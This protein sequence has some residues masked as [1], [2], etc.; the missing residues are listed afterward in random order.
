MGFLQ[1]FGAVF[2]ALILS[3]VAKEIYKRYVEKITH[4]ALDQIEIEAKGI[5]EDVGIRK[6]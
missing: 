2:L 4:K 5:I 3:E 6:K 1:T